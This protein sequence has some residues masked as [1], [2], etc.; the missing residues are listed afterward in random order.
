MKTKRSVFLL[1]SGI[2]G[3]AYLIYIISHFFGSIV[4]ADDMATAIGSSLAT[5]LVTPHIMLVAL[6]VIFNWIGYLAN[7][8]WA[9]LTGGILY[10]VGGVLFILY[11]IFVIPSIVLS[12]IGTS[13]LKKAQN[14]AGLGDF[15]DETWIDASMVSGID[16]I[17]AN[18]TVR[19][20]LNNETLKIKSKS[21]GQKT[22]NIHYPQITS[23]NLDGD[24]NNETFSIHCVSKKDGGSKTLVFRSAQG[25]FTNEIQNFVSELQEK[26]QQKR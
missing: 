26:V 9:A 18:E 17:P 1:V 25:N 12:F 3:L 16:A 23:L 8:S 19:L 11:I 4:G 20:L 13:K 10:V 21:L 14:N 2:I 7:K 6:A 5:A 15:D 24:G 22:L